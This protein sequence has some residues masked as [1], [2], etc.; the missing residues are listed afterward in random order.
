MFSHLYDH[1]VNVDIDVPLFLPLYGQRRQ[2]DLRRIALR[3]LR[4]NF[5][6]EGQMN[7]DSG[8]EWGYWLSDV[9]TA[10]ASWDPYLAVAPEASLLNSGTC[11]SRA[12]SA[13]GSTG[14]PGF[15][16]S[17]V[18]TCLCFTDVMC[19]W[20]SF[21]SECAGGTYTGKE[22]TLDPSYVAADDQWLAH[23]FALL[24]YTTL[25][26]S[27][28][29]PR[30][31]ALI[32]ELSQAQAELLIKGRINGTE[33]PGLRKLGGMAYLSGGD[34][35]VDIPRMFGLAFTQPDKIHIKESHDADW[36]HAMRLLKEM[37]RVFAEMSRKM[38]ALN[39][40]VRAYAQTHG[41]AVE[42]TKSHVFH[43]NA[44][45]L[46]LLAEISDSTRMLALRA[47]QVRLLYQSR[48]AVIGAEE[49]H[50]K[51]LQRQA[52]EVVHKAEEVR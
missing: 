19:V 32:V 23:S 52:R 4:E 3:E 50:R 10:R 8:W 40:E 5:R 30:L 20:F 45:A 25:Y 49:H 22:L 11:R 15:F 47:R 29:G 48:D 41:T 14:T 16:P 37:D 33:S 1:R 51:D 26:G 34:T 9:V 28:Y 36:P 43:I 39:E 2:H 35:W 46:E 44:P 24:P 27:L 42:C 38:S 31:N 18:H 13:D 17:F 6:M 7:F 21:S 12:D